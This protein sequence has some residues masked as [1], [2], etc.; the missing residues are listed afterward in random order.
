[1]MK[2]ALSVENLSK[3]YLSGKKKTLDVNALNNI[4]LEVKQG[5]FSGYLAQMELEKQLF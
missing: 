2:T 3:V 1:M 5:K 4:T